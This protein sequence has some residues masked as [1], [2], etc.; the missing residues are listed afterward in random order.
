MLL[1]LTLA[2]NLAVPLVAQSVFCVEHRGKA[3][4]VRK[5]QRARPFVMENGKLVTATAER[6]GLVPAPE[7][8]PI[9]IAVRGLEVKWSYVQLVGRMSGDINHELQFK[10]DFESPYRLSNVFL[11]LELDTEED[12]KECFPYEI[13]E[14]GPD[15]PREVKL[16]AQLHAALGKGRYQ[17]HLFADGAEVFHSEQPWQF[18]ENMLD[19]M[20][21]KRIAGVNEAKSKPFIGPAPEYPVAL[22]KERI[23]GEAVVRFRITTTGAVVDPTVERAT[24]PA[25]GKAALAAVRLWRFLPQVKD[26]HAVE[27]WA[28]MPFAFTPPAPPANG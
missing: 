2:A 10:A 15:R 25:F 16:T 3:C 1:L 13:G 8:L 11:V 17:L 4:V 21:L 20:V 6:S 22:L 26:G 27:T 12:G 23:Q 28:N 24:D 7:F 5:M 14:L 18:R 9:F 19:R